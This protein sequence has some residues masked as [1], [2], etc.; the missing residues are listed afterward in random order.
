VAEVA[1]VDTRA[2]VDERRRGGSY[3]SIADLA[4]RSGAGAAALQR[5]AWAGACDSLVD[6][7]VREAKPSATRLI[8]TLPVD[9]EEEH[10]R[11]ALWAVGGAARAA[12]TDDGA[13]LA[14]PLDG[15]PTPQLPPL[16]PWERIVADYRMTGITLGEH[17][18]E[19]LRPGLPQ[20][21]TG[22]SSAS[23]AQDP[24]ILTSE[25]LGRTRDGARVKV[26]GMVVARQ[27]PA[28][29]NGV[30][31]MLLEDERGTINLIVPPPV[32][33]RCRLAV[34]TSGFVQA[35]GKL[36]HREG[37]TNVVVSRIERLERP[38]LRQIAPGSNGLRYRAPSHQRETGRQGHRIP[39]EGAAGGLS[40]RAF[41]GVREA[42]MAELAASLPAP[43]SF[44]RRGR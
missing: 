19:L 14:L 30:V 28:T 27:R 8:S 25:G 43:H 11:P 41:N 9:P 16:G 4:G 21:E 5:F 12:R 20:H 18:M 40:K 42:A 15:S 35:A 24:R 6:A 2:V 1:D 31:F 23:P 34:R 32:V 36:E 7:R 17:P 29:A 10:R 39:L 33:E 22:S 44:G 38:D 3:R 37:T 13:Q 26:A